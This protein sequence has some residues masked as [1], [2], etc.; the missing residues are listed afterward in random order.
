M[1]KWLITTGLA[2]DTLAMGITIVREQLQAQIRASGMLGGPDYSDPDE[3][4]DSA[5]EPAAL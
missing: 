3:A 5:A 2:E 4:A 1:I